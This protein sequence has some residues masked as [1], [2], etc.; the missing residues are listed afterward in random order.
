MDKTLYYCPP[1]SQADEA[2]LVSLRPTIHRRVIAG[3]LSAEDLR[4]LLSSVQPHPQLMASLL[5]MLLEEAVVFASL[6]GSLDLR[7]D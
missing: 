2:L 1:L 4:R 3:G 6:S 7:W 5:D